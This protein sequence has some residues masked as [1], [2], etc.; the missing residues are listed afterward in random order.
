MKTMRL[1]FLT[2]IALTFFVLQSCDTEKPTIISP[3]TAKNIA[4]SNSTAEAFFSDVFDQAQSATLSAKDSVEGGKNLASSNNFCALITIEPFDLTTFPKDITVDF[5][6]GCLGNDGKLR[7]G[8]IMINA[9]N[10]FKETGSIITVGLENYSVSDF[11]VEGTNTI[12][13]NGLNSDNFLS[14]NFQVK[15]GKI[16][17]PENNSVTQWSSNRTIEWIKGEETITASDDEYKITGTQNG[18]TAADEEY[19]IEITEAIHIDMSCEWRIVAGKQTI[20]S[21]KEEIFIDYGDG[22]CDNK[23]IVSYKGLSY[24]VTIPQ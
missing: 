13:N 4:L 9:T 18:I 1:L 11:G 23:F 17:N 15:N 22:T 2:S 19:S 21:K 12:T 20:T 5:G 10:W 6:E 16:T 24:V 3:E 8:K 14:Y 7:K